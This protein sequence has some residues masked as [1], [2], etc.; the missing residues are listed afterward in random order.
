MGIFIDGYDT[1]EFKFHHKWVSSFRPSLNHFFQPV[2]LQAKYKLGNHPTWDIQSFTNARVY[3]IEN[4]C[5]SLFGSNKSI[6]APYV[7]LPNSGEIRFRSKA[8]VIAFLMMI[9]DSFMEIT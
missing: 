4:I 3:D 8:Y 5:E 6:F 9:D 7:I 1:G 2:S